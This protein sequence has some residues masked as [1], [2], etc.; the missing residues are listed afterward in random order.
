MNKR[1]LIIVLFFQ[2][3]IYGQSPFITTWETTVANETITI[4]TFPGETYNYTVDWGDGTGV[5]NE[6]G[7]AIHTYAVANTYTVSIS[8]NFP[9][10]Y[11]NNSG[12]KDKILTIEQWG[13]QV[14]T[15][16]EN[17]FYGCSNLNITNT[18][19]DDP[20]L[21]NVTDM[22]SMFY[23]TS[24]FTGAHIEGW[25]TGNVT[26]M[27]SMFVDAI[28]FNGDLSAWDV[29][30]V[31]SMLNMFLRAENF[32]QDISGWDVR[33][34]QSMTAMFSG[35]V[36]FNQDIGFKV[37]TGKG[38]S[39]NK[40]ESMSQMF[41]NATAF[42]QDIGGWNTSSV[43]DMSRMFEKGPFA[44]MPNN[45]NQDISNWDVSN[46]EDMSHMFS[47][48]EK[49]N[50][51]IGFN[52]TTGK[53]WNTS[54][55]KN[56]Y[57]M[58]F[59]TD[60]FNGDISGWNTG[61]VENMRGMFRQAKKFNQDIGGW[62]V[63][64]VTTMTL[65]FTDAIVFNQ[66]IGGWDTSNVERMSNMFNRAT[67]FNQD[68]SGW[69]TSKV[70]SMTSMFAEAENFNQNI[71]FDASTGSW[72]TSSV[73]NMS[74]MFQGAKAFN[75]NISN[76]DVK[77]VTD[78]N[79]MFNG[80]TIFNQDISGWAVGNVKN[81][82][83]MF[84]RASA[85]NQDIGGWDVR[86]VNS[87][88]QMFN[89]AIE[90]NKDI[91]NWKLENATELSFMFKDAVKFNQDIGKWRTLG[92]TTFLNQMFE[93]AIAFDQDISSW[94]VSKV[95]NM[96][97]M[98]HRA[99]LSTANYDA[100]LKGW[101]AQVLQ[102]NVKFSGG[103]STY[104]TATTERSNMEIS[105]SWTITDGG[106]DC[107]ST[108]APF[109]ATWQTT[110]PNESITIP[111]FAGE[112]YNYTVDWGDGSTPTVE[113][114]NAT[115]TYTSPNTYTVSISGDFP[116]IYFNNNGDKDK[117]VTIEQW[118]NQEWTSMDSAFYGCSNVTITNT[119]ID[120]PDLTKVT[121]MVR[122]FSNATAFNGDLSGWITTNVEDMRFA[123]TSA[124]NF[125]ADISGWDTS[126]VTRMSYMFSVA[127]SFNRDISN[128]N[129]AAVTEMSGMFASASEFNQ[130]LGKVGGWDTSKVT[131][132]SFMFRGATKFNG[133]LSEWNTSLITNMSQM[134]AKAKVFNRDI[135]DWDTSSVKNM[136]WMFEGAS[137]FNQDLGKVG[138]WDTSSVENMTVMF[139]G[140]K[141][142]NGD[143]SNWNT[144][145]VTNMSLMFDSA[146]AFNTDISGWNTENVTTMA[147]M[148]GFTKLFNSDISGWNTSKVT[149]M[150][151]MF[152]GAIA[153][154]QNLGGWNVTA[155]TNMTSMFKDI[156]LSTTNY[157]A[158]LKGWNAQILK[159]NI[160]FDGGNSTYCTAETERNNIITTNMWMITDGGKEA[161]PVVDNIADVNQPDMF[162]FPTITGKNLSG[163]EK[164]Y[165]QPGG[166]G[167]SYMGGDIINYADFPTYPIILYAYDTGTCGVSEVN[168]KLTLTKTT[169]T[170]PITITADA[171]SKVY[172][173]ADPVLT[174]TITS[175]SLDPGDVLTGGLTRVVG[176]DVG[177][178]TIN[179][180]L[181]NSNYTITY[182]P[183][184]LN[185]TAK[186]IT[187]TADAKSKV[188]G[189]V[190]PVLTY[191]IT[192]GSLE[193]GDVLTGGLTRVAGE[194]VGNYTINS[195][196]SNSNYTITYIPADLNITAKPI[197]ITA[198]AK[199]KVYGSADPVLTYTI[200]SGSLETG[201]VLTGGLTRVAGE[202][203]GNYLINSNLSNPN[204]TITYVPADLNITAK[205]ITITADVKSKVYGSVDPILTY[206]ITSGSLETGDVLT[207]G[208]TRVAGEDVG[209]YTINSNLSNPNYT[210]TYVPADLSITAKPI[211]ITADAKSKV[212]GSADL[213]LT[214]AVTSGS[215]ETGDVLTGGLTRIAGEDIGNYTIN[216]NL[217]N[218]NYTI[219]YVPAD[220]SITAK[221]ITI[222]ADAKSKVYGS[223]DPILMY[224]VTSGSLETGDVLTG[225]LTRIAGEDIGNYTINSNLSNSNY[226]ITYVSADLS[227]TAKPITITADAKSKAYGSVDPILTYTITP[228]SLET[229]DVLAGGLTRIAGEDIGN[230]T[231][232]SNLSNPN[233]T[234]TYVPADLSIT[235]KPITITADAKSK[236]YG[237]ADPVLTY[238]IT[239]GSLETGDVL[240]GGL[241]R[242][243]GEDVGTY[244]INSNLSNS[245]Y[246]ITYVPADLS[247][248]AKPITITADAK[249]K[250]YGSTDPVLTY[251]ITSGS[252]ET[253]D[254]LTGGLTRIVGEDVGMYTINSNLSNSNYTI[255]YVP[256]DLSITAKPITITADAK[257]KAYG[258]ADPVLT[259]TITAGSLETGDALIGSLEREIG[260]EV[261][262]YE[263]FQGDLENT[264]Y[265]ITFISAS[266][267]IT[268]ISNSIVELPNVFTPNGDGTN[269]VF[270]IKDLEKSYPNFEIQFFD[271]NGSELYSYRHNGNPLDIPLWWDGTFKGEK[272]PTGTYYFSL[273]YNNGVKKPKTTWV[274][275]NR[276]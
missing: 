133:D 168:F 4:P 116:R 147:G 241:V 262:I 143:L 141:K 82:G 15:S 170:K 159:P 125:N 69:D 187:I 73:T 181:S 33:N 122:M 184:D 90:F 72:N 217:S 209:M 38:W 158:L 80:A 43:R 185:I 54:K 195:N 34:V 62:D 77:Q 29:G 70:K 71:N 214:Y 210:I 183:A 41:H 8:G 18:G 105:D 25:K 52:A 110:T 260:E 220:L 152:N 85:F 65:M 23:Q 131:D 240:T 101:N 91:G 207:G 151:S 115:H 226:T 244:A 200:T 19:I 222:T 102:P 173:S 78:M 112:M 270:E 213:I 199:S 50:Q 63:S 274:F 48:A 136:M 265:D 114:G 178:Y 186:P 26:N 100:L 74:K 121:S 12:D 208:L 190:D 59:G 218:P 68:I 235:A 254:V 271:R 117:I 258:S 201:D 87:F 275:L 148:F 234:I 153:F 126:K 135:S 107:S 239:L 188:Y 250:V 92:N 253:G 236:V 174:Y 169:T 263:I 249:S 227:I 248:T 22:S 163:A 166:L 224:A 5:T 264:N 47:R 46:V 165:T 238:T 39:T 228:G 108:S 64:K 243:T 134:F 17:A 95:V 242:I 251:T 99:K 205:P 93:N 198:D 197:T 246:T 37:S 76:W 10:I 9:R 140:A 175:G 276:Q 256:A 84:S 103:N 1:V 156:K 142:F 44:A 30:S 58:F 27:T 269:D 109:I 51:D 211:T 216:S 212:Y 233:Y 193:T 88:S 223:A 229:G 139:R 119:S 81:M 206:T 132:M 89:G 180:N 155:V 57:N 144:S 113:T 31:R 160:N 35:A 16:M 192:S 94:D 259:Y 164:Y 191:T 11:F 129:V 237:S 176:E 36:K 245:N 96:F 111:T 204:Y 261:G 79:N 66:D 182:I 56:M 167:T 97:L 83:A 145:S 124:E 28:V 203:V 146:S 40:V 157:D 232:N 221:P 179:S 219:T 202:D 120:V 104:C 45:F 7:D 130:D 231:I 196:L 161:S 138:G 194:D 230:Y 272:L 55:V 61:S 266:F 189:S 98:F 257:S 32:N 255:T 225:G 123:F 3:I 86:N 247:I 127:K 172:G 14:W 154:D 252:L 6:T 267:E 42:N 150:G 53:G 13:D 20:D 21:T 128:W 49:F 106:L 149:N 215:L 24:S 118:G 75:G 162:T 60:E 273:N 137:E 268:G 171:K 177:N 2:Y 67:E